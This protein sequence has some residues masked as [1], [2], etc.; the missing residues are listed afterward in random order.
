MGLVLLFVAGLLGVTHRSHS[1]VTYPA[2]Y[3]AAVSAAREAHLWTPMLPP[4]DPQGMHV[5]VA[6]YEPETSGLRGSMRL[7]VGW[8]DG[9]QGYVALWQGNGDPSRMLEGAVRGATCEQM[10]L[11]DANGRAW[12]PCTGKRSDRALLY[13]SHGVTT[14]V[15]GNLSSDALQEIAASLR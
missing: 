3:N 1:Q 5:S 15:Y 12:M 11:P 4:K 14:I 9:G 13:S 8:S 6:R 2:D 10:A 7:Y